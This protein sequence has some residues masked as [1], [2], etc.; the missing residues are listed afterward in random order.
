MRNM[1]NLLIQLTFDSTINRLAGR[2][3]F[4]GSVNRLS[5]GREMDNNRPSLV[6]VHSH[7]LHLGL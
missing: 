1:R 3:L 7:N 6:I 4:S 2:P 5:L